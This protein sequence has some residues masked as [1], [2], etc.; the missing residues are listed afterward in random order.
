MGHVLT[1]VISD[2]LYETLNNKARAASQSPEDLVTQW[3]ETASQTVDDPFEKFI[4]SIHS[5]IPDWANRHDYYLGLSIA[6][7]MGDYNQ[8]GFIRLLK[9]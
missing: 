1:L 6:E 7:S 3:L 8:A 4:G 2:E 5:D 9:D